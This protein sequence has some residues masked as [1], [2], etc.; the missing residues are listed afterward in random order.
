MARIATSR[1]PPAA[2]VFPDVRPRDVDAT[3]LPLPAPDRPD[4]LAGLSIVVVTRDD[5]A[6]AASALPSA[7]RAAA[8]TSH[9]YEIV[10]VDDGSSD[11]TAAVIARFCRPGGRVRLLV[12]SQPLGPGAA[13][14][15]G[16]AASSMPWIL[17][18]DASDELDLAGLEDFLPLAFEHD[19]LLGWR[20][21]RR[22]PPAVRAG[23]AIWNRLVSRA[24]GVSVRDVDC[25]AKLVKRDF[26]ERARL[27]STGRTIGA[28][29]LVEAERLDA[30][31]AEVHVH[32]RIEP[33]SGEKSGPSPRPGIRTLLALAQLRRRLRKPHPRRLAR[34]LLGLGVAA[35]AVVSG[36][37]WLYELRSAGLLG[38]GPRLGGALP[39][40]QLAGDDSQPLLRMAGAWLP[41]G[42]VSG[43][44]LGYVARVHRPPLCTALVG[45]VLLVAA[46]A[47]SDAIA[48]SGLTAHLLPQFTRP[49]LWGALI[50]LTIGAA[51]AAR[52]G[53]QP[54]P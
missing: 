10:A 35:M 19:L 41:A 52:L 46:G 36:V 49:G 48:S 3:G 39:L 42:A 21:M 6:T 45:A 29:L 44:G 11:E 16:V 51:L 50:L 24:L 17:L 18:I 53:L 47:A 28:E 25:P 4:A 14:R 1:P 33:V 23:A 5:A 7:A 30:S 34:G 43:F 9:D 13:L 12:H 20:V 26:L 2:P 15:A 40:Q 38:A 31:V 37:G 54:R 8:R 32:Q 27:V 22:G